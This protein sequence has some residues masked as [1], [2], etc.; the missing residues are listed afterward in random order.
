M[1]SPNLNTL[2]NMFINE[3]AAVEPVTSDLP[4]SLF[5]NQGVV[6]S[7]SSSN[8]SSGKRKKIL[9][10][11]SHCHQYN[12]NSK[13]SWNILKLLSQEM[14]FEIQHFGIMQSKKTNIDFRHYPSNVKYYSVSEMTQDPYGL[15]IL[16][17]V[18]KDFE[19][20][21]IVLFNSLQI[22]KKYI[23]VLKTQFS[24]KLV[25][26]LDMC[27]YSTNSETLTLLNDN[28]SHVFTT[29][30]F[31]KKNLGFQGLTVPVSIFPYGFDKSCFP[32]L[33]KTNTREGISLPKD[34][35]L[36]LNP[37][38]NSHKHRYDIVLSAFVR[39]ISKYPTHKIHLFCLC[40]KGSDGGYPVLDIYLS[41]LRKYNVGVED[42]LGKILLVQQDQNYSDQII[43]SIFNCAN[44]GI[45]CPDSEGGTLAAIE[46]MGVGVPQ[47][48]PKSGLYEEFTNNNNSLLLPIKQSYYVT[49]NI[50]EVPGEARAVDAHDVFLALEKYLL[51][52]SLIEEH[53]RAARE[54]VIELTW[55]KAASEFICYLKGEV[56][57]Q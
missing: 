31:W 55:E 17:G 29:S 15:D 19:P 46:M 53:G 11:S 1:Y 49:N 10:I 40:D 26:Y 33:D 30:A 6:K 47:I 42:H 43:N 57:R 8:S 12:S 16:G 56:T 13:V 48:L 4:F 28:L 45:S 44:I 32:V 21:V 36:I 14:E 41:E 23:E 20:D 18:I 27:Y 34:S 24:G 9:L 51:M 5:P 54:T 38:R 37:N 7:T 22:V 25:G 3:G 39:L 2:M 35:F 50:S 52:P